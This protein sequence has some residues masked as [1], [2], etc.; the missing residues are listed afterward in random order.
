MSWLK[1]NPNEPTKSSLTV[2][3]FAQSG[4]PSFDRLITQMSTHN[5]HR[6]MCPLATKKFN[7]F[8]KNSE[9]KI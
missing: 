3:K 1:K 9:N 2:E 5:I 7:R 6:M 4:H 8:F